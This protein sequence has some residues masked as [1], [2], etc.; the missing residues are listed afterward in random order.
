MRLGDRR[1]EGRYTD[2][3]EVLDRKMRLGRPSVLSTPPTTLVERVLL[4]RGRDDIQGGGLG[5]YMGV[6]RGVAGCR[7]PTGIRTKEARAGMIYPSTATLH[8]QA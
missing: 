8:Q 7:G 5:K 4:R 3:V 1:Y 6:Y 2:H